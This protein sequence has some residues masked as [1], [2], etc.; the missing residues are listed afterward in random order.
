MNNFNLSKLS[1]GENP[2]HV[3]QYRAFRLG[4]LQLLKPS[5]ARQNAGTI[6]AR[7]IR[8]LRLPKWEILKHLDPPCSQKHS[9]GKLGS[10]S[11]W[12][13][14]ESPYHHPISS[15]LAGRTMKHHISC[16]SFQP[17]HILALE[18]QTVN[19]LQEH[20]LK[21]ESWTKVNTNSLTRG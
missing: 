9:Q 16:A 6:P 21:L 15:C 4:K 20:V 11:Q 2:S 17:C 10:G 13:G 19:E 5:K 7:W 14:T 18:A 3:H 1:L 8:W 12:G